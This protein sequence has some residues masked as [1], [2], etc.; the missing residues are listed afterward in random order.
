M[1]MTL[2]LM[3]KGDKPFSLEK[4]TYET[5][6]SSSGHGLSMPQLGCS[7]PCDPN[8]SGV[9]LTA[10]LELLGRTRIQAHPLVFGC[11]IRAL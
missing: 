7:T 6:G 9:Y 8:L 2:P 1:D 10:P 11:A 5:W 3:K 4:R